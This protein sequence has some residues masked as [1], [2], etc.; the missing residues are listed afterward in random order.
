MAVAPPRAAR[1]A[2]SL[3]R[4]AARATASGQARADGGAP[5]RGR[6]R[7][8]RRLWIDLWG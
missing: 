7:R 1:G 2:R 6:G 5:P 4:A 8:G 3:S